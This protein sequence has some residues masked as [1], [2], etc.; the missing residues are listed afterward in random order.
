MSAKIRSLYGASCSVGNPVVGPALVVQAIE[1][2]RQRRQ[3]RR[4][5]EAAGAAA[6]QRHGRAGVGRQLRILAAINRQL[7]HASWIA[8]ERAP[9]ADPAR[10]RPASKVAVMVAARPPRRCP[11]P[12]RPRCGARSVSPAAARASAPAGD[13]AAP[14]PEARDQI[15]GAWAGRAASAAADRRRQ[16]FRHAGATPTRWREAR[17]RALRGRRV[18]RPRSATD[19]RAHRPRRGRRGTS[20]R[21]RRNV[22]RAA[23]PG[24][25][26]ARCSHALAS[27]PTPT[28]TRF[29]SHAGSAHEPPPGVEQRRR[30]PCGD[31]RARR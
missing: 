23:E 2:A 5:R 4:L 28:T 13:V 10:R 6:L 19:A 12:C 26:R 16:P 22:M 24:R 29:A 25:A 14:E 7:E 20:D 21:N 1:E 9:A 15:V 17:G 3:R 18:R 30:S 31:R 11:R 27:A 8:R